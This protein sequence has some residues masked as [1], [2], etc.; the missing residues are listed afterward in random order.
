MYEDDYQ[1]LY[2]YP[3][4]Y[5]NINRRLRKIICNNE[6]CHAITETGL[7]FSW[8]HDI[9][10][11][12]TLG[13]GDNIYQ[14]NTPVLNKY[15]SKHL[16]FDISLSEEHCAAI[17]FNNCMYTWG[18][19]TNGEL[20]F[21]D[22]KD[23]IV[24]I[25]NKV[26]CNGKPFLVE[27]IKCG[28]HYTTGIT[29]DG[30]PFLFGNKNL[31]NSDINNDN[32]IFFS[33]KNTTAKDVYCGDN[34]IIILLEK[35]K[36]LIYDFNIGLFEILLNNEDYN[37]KNIIIS[38]INVVDK[39]FY[40]L[41]EKN[42]K[43]YEFVYQSR[44]Y[45]KS[46]NIKD[47]YLT[48]YEI[49]KDVKLS[50][51]EMP[52]FVKF[53]FFW[54]ECSE[55]QKKSFISQEKKI[56]KKIQDKDINSFK[57][58]KN[59]KGPYINENFLFGNNKRRIELKK[60]EFENSYKRKRI[61][62][63]SKEDLIKNNNKNYDFKIFNEENET[64]DS[65]EEY[66]NLPI[67]KNYG[68][69]N[70]V[71]DKKNINLD[72]ENFNS[73]NKY[74]TIN[75]ENEF[76]KISNKRNSKRFLSTDESRR[77]SSIS[78]DKKQSK[79]TI[80]EYQNEE[81][82]DNKS[83]INNLKTSNSFLI[84]NKM[85]FN[86]IIEN[87]NDKYS[88]NHIYN[89][90][91]KEGSYIQMKEDKN[92]KTIN[93]E[94][95]KEFDNILRNINN[96]KLMI[97]HP[98]KLEDQVPNTKKIISKIG[99]TKSK[100]EILI[101]E[102][103]ETFFGKENKKQNIYNNYLNHNYMR[104]NIINKEEIKEENKNDISKENNKEK[105]IFKL[106]KNK[107]QTGVKIMKSYL[108]EEKEQ[109]EI[110]FD[111]DKMKD[112]EIDINKILGKGKN[113]FKKIKKKED[114]E[115]NGK[116]IDEKEKLNMELK[117]ENEKLEK[118]IK[119]IKEKK[120]EEQC[121]LKEKIKE[122]EMKKDLIEKELREK[123]E[124]E[125]KD[126]YEKEIKENLKQRKN[127]VMAS[128]IN[129]FIKGKNNFE[130]ENEKK[131]NYN[132]SNNY[133]FIPERLKT[134]NEN[135]FVM[136]GINK[137]NYNFT[138][139]NKQQ[140]NIENKHDNQEKKNI[141]NNNNNDKLNLNIEDIISTRDIIFENNNIFNNNISQKIDNLISPIPRQTLNES[142]NISKNEFNIDKDITSQQ[143]ITISELIQ[144]NNSNHSKNE[145]IKNKKENENSL[146]FLIE[147]N[148]QR[149]ESSNINT[150]KEKDDSFGNINLSG[151]NPEK[152][153]KSLNLREQENEENE[154]EIALELDNSKIK[155][156]MNRKEKSKA[157]N[158]INE[159]IEEK[160]EL[161][162]LEDT[163]KSKN[164]VRNIY[165]MNNNNN[166]TEKSLNQM[167]EISN[168]N[169]R[170]ISTYDQ[171]I[172]STIRKFEPKE[173]DDIT[174]SLRFFSNRSDN[175]LSSLTNKNNNKSTSEINNIVNLNISNNI[176]NLK[177]YNGLGEKAKNINDTNNL[178]FSKNKNLIIESEKDKE[179]CNYEINNI[180][181][182]KDQKMK[183]DDL[184]QSK[185]LSGKDENNNNIEL[186]SQID[187]I[188]NILYKSNKII[189][190]KNKEELRNILNEINQ[191]EK[192][193][194]NDSLYFLLE[195]DS[196]LPNK[197]GTIEKEVNLLKVK[198][199]KITELNSGN[200]FILEDNNKNQ[201]FNN[202]LKYL[203]LMNKESLQNY[204]TFSEKHNLIE[205]NSINKNKNNNIKNTNTN[206]NITRGIQIKTM[207]RN[208]SYGKQS[209]KK[210]KKKIGIIEQIKKEQ[211]EKK[212]QI[213]YNTFNNRNKI[214]LTNNNVA[215]YIN[216]KP[217]KYSKNSIANIGYNNTFHY[218]PG[219]IPININMNMNI[220]HDEN[221][222]NN[223]TSKNIINNNKEKDKESF[224]I[225]RKKYL[226]FLI[227]VYGN[228]NI[229]NNKDNEKMDNTF[230]KGL[231]NNEVPIENINLNLLKCSSDMKNFIGESLENFKLQQI[232][233]KIPKISE[234]NFLYLN[235]NNNEKMQLD[236]DDD[237]K[238]KSN[239][240]EPI[241][242]DK[243][244]NYNLNFRK[245]FVESLSGI[246]NE[247]KFLKSENISNK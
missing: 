57:Y 59:N 22:K 167:Q 218:D 102:L 89:K 56:F 3:I 137:K 179:K 105:K 34:Y 50:I 79:R 106:K 112:I 154:P 164:K 88:F 162:S 4:N 209:N 219:M 60:V 52:F 228:E 39:N 184:E 38:K 182:I 43:L 45:S 8:G 210:L 76:N 126:K 31:E 10:H 226:D 61:N 98:I 47:F 127:L 232:K 245:S 72:F 146:N 21:F 134:E 116:I 180:E 168:S 234:N 189:K 18:L 196:T 82:I 225:L 237:I 120:E 65:K 193:V 87:K 155:L 156:N 131:V 205:N 244:N 48:E 14:V 128:E 86:N 1:F 238:D 92:S 144:K 5:S 207:N 216:I 2:E 101:K 16:I 78:L 158:R 70:D 109:N 233:E 44:N 90:R 27:K 214:I 187:G 142:K 190:L 239:I 147:D 114:I 198:N 213:I 41:D 130:N 17:D 170:H 55:S 145:E 108:D 192:N 40:V 246:K 151:K 217:Q 195:S 100:T 7:V 35:E 203:N 33:L 223:K 96:R 29:N 104:N 36:L 125:Y 229:P 150:N 42:K 185:L 58:N 6:I 160:Q 243:S 133:K 73:T 113:R 194:L 85:N 69:K 159:I 30:I 49:N 46:L 23:R 165:L 149:N 64:I 202:K 197:Q 37:N 24:S 54:I 63:F 173:L 174:G 140:I 201:I 75:N 236:Y 135:E 26:I 230:L 227:K 204:H 9:H 11:K 19:G 51:I 186:K 15:L 62:I 172:I 157:K 124:I 123:L 152:E 32:I 166:P 188:K 74:K 191:E 139:S 161:E 171:N 240:L 12:G 222:K 177:P 138:I 143:S 235:T 247:N 119:E 97:N 20:G 163:N 211:Y 136:K 242:L 25:P 176:S 66:L 93:K 241:E 80:N 208:K 141:I 71:K 107:D 99:R 91:N 215:P 199:N 110:N 220:M 84:Q 68:N 153:Q 81:T 129:K 83:N 200:N 206:T 103:H 28:M 121:I 175:I 95:E 212:Q 221:N 77:N 132:K 118:E 178:N 13:L 169:M 183:I 115:E 181:N 111:Y 231:I 148:N 94:E 117:L 224:I 67:S 122:S 53:L